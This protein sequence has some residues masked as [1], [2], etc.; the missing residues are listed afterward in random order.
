M[1]SAPIVEMALSIWM[2]NQSTVMARRGM[3]RGW[4]TTP[5]VIVSA[6]SGVEVGVAAD[7][8]VIL[9]GRVFAPRTGRRQ[10]LGQATRVGGGDDEARARI[11][12]A[13]EG[14]HVRARTAPG[15]SARGRRGC[16]RRGSG[17]PGSGRRS[18]RSCRCRSRSCDRPRH[19]PNS[20][21]RASSESSWMKL[22][23]MIGM[24]T[25][26]KASRTSYS[27]LTGS[28]APPWPARSPVWKATS[29]RKSAPPCDTRRRPRGRRPLFAHGNW[30]P[31]SPRLPVSDALATVSLD[32]AALE[33]GR[34]EIVERRR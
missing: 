2:S 17:H 9:V 15:C 29:V 26:A 25:S 18:R 10:A 1:V 8:A 24:R 21:S 33:A 19:S 28:V 23:S 34:L 4:M 3:K 13:V 5:T 14:D 11:G 22:S 7:Q 30:M 31:Y 32:Q 27:P 12:G 16:S 6:I 20:G